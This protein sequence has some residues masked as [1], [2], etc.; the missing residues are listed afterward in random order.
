MS[1]P[2]RIYA[3]AVMG[4]VL[5]SMANAAPRLLLS[6]TSVGPLYVATGANG[7]AQTV[8]AFNA[9]DG[10][11]NLSI[12]TSASWLGAALATPAPCTFQATGTCT[13]IQ[14][15]L[16]TSALADGTYTEFVVVTAPG[17]VDSPQQIQ[18]T[19]T[20]ANVPANVTLY[21]APNGGTASANIYPHSTVVGV[22]STQSGGNWLTLQNP[23]GLPPYTFGSAYSVQAITQS[24]QAPGTYTGTIAIGGSTFAADNQNVTVTL[25]VTNS[26]IIQV[27][28]TGV[29]LTGFQGGPKATA[30]V[31]FTNLGFGTLS[32][33][34]AAGTSPNNFLS[35]SVT[36]STSILISA[37]PSLLSPGFYSGTV[38]I[39]SNA[40]NNAQVS[41]PVELNVSAPG[42]AI[43]QGGIVN[44]ANFTSEAVAPGDIVAVFGDQFSPGDTVYTNSSLPLAIT[45]NTTQVWVNGVAA[46][47]YFVSRQQV[48][49]QVPYE[50]IA[51]QPATVQ[52]VTNGT[53]STL[54]SI[55]IAASVPRILVWA[56]SYVQGGYGVAVNPDSTLALPAGTTIGAFNS[57]PTKAGATLILY[58][59]GLGQT[60]PAATTGAAAGSAPVESTTPVTVT[61][62]NSTI[63]V[64]A[65]SAFSGLVPTLVGLYQI[66]VQVPNGVPTGSSVPITL[67]L[68]G[69]VSNSVNI[70]ISQ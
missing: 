50:V 48:N 40:A 30:T 65:Q 67:S 43:T 70:A 14:I 25:N 53:S 51:G 55:P 58:A 7:T 15:S 57:H 61:F 29:K 28:N 44:I 62:G 68:N 1:L 59:V 32:I 69:N 66:N 21:A 64:T 63:P 34:S 42:P 46:P 38:T 9:G 5:T 41:I 39:A 35:A 45:L 36:N 16:N 26:P 54:R 52:V 4:V 22:I 3:A 19:I 47:L 10:A 33:S 49:F 13:P 56:S 20:I 27:A 2:T 60:N 23:S 6:K 24:G 17:A 37:D 18:V 12:A 8:E 31:N 11:L